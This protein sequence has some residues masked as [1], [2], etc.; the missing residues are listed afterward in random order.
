M[1]FHWLYPLSQNQAILNLFR[2]IT[3]RSFIAFVVAIVVSL[4]WGKRFISLMKLRQFGQ[5]IR[6]D[7]PQSHLKK[8]GTPTFGGV[9]IIGSALVATLVCG[10]FISTPFLITMFVMLSYFVLGGLDDYFKVLKKNSK[11]VSAKQKLLWQFLTAGFACYFM[12]KYN[13]TDT[14]LYQRV[15]HPFLTKP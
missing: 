15:E 9:F 8:K 7:G 11:G 5:S 2:Y 13:V 14:Q 3:V 12:I 1:L 4:I 10:N 6:E